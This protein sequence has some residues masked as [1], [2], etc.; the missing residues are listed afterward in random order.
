MNLPE[1]LS[2]RDVIW[3][4]IIGASAFLAILVNL[5]GLLRGISVVI[6]HLLYIPVVIAAY[7]YPKWGLSIAACIGG[8]YLLIVFL[9]AANSFITITEAFVRTLVVIIIGGLIAWL[10]FRL[11]ER[12]DLYQGVF[13]QS[14]AGNILIRDT[15]KGRIIEEVNEKAARVLHRTTRELKG[16][17][18][19]LFWGRDSELNVFSRL[20][21]GGT[22]FVAESDFLLPDGGS[23][24]VLLSAAPLPSGRTIITFVEITRRVY[25]EK[26]LKIANDK[27]SLLSRI[28]NDHLQRTADQMA[29]TA[30]EA[31]VQCNDPAARVFF[32]R[33]RE[34]SANLTRQLKLAESYK[35]LGLSPPAWL[36]VRKILDSPD[37]PLPVQSVFFRFWTERLEIYADPLFKDVLVHIT[38]NAIIHGISTKNVIVTYH[39][40][41]E[42]LDL[43]LEDDGV[44][45]P[46]GMKQRIF[47]Y[48]AGGHNGLGLFICREILGV[49]GMTISESGMEG[50][51][52]RFVI[53]VPPEGYRIEGT[54]EES[55]AFPLPDTSAGS[56]YQVRHSSGTIVRELCSA[57]FPRAETL[58]IEYHPTKGDPR[59]TG[60]LRDLSKRRSSL[61]HGAGRTRMAL[62]WMRCLLPQC[63]VVAGTHTRYCGVWSKPAGTI[64]S[65]CIQSGT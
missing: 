40:T 44:G 5:V 18:P 50:K 55:P 53:H 13:Y 19:S 63:T 42:G 33:M 62:K 28:A 17:P 22:V 58:W 3:D 48:D 57:E 36:G 35:N 14:E 24:T 52:A 25:A 51:S 32:D 23:E 64:P 60:S 9:V 31:E 8:L 38:G 29:E 37:I 59:T 54:E 1:I 61:W 65:L 30:D 43:F 10:S 49:T 26:A 27:L 39:E 47:E 21:A 15:E 2:S 7:R 56:L 16:A 12:E 11:R 20:N 46:A 34:L 6:P 45:I 41:P 4:T